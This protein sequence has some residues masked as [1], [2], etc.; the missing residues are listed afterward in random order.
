MRV[1]GDVEIL[2]TPPE[3]QI[4]HAASHEVGE[5][6]GRDEAIEHLQHVG[7]DIATRD[8]VLGPF[9]Y[10]RFQSLFV[11]RGSEAVAPVRN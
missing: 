3:H 1:G 11:A 5:L 4:A 6:A 10:M 2:G 7:I 8:G 9:E